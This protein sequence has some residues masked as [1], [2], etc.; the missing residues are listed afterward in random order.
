MTRKESRTNAFMLLFS[1]YAND[2]TIPEDTLELDDDGVIEVDDFCRRIIDNTRDNLTEIDSRI[3][4]HLQGWTIDRLP[5][6]S[7]AILRLSAAQLL[8][9][10]DIPVPVVISEAVELAKRFGSSNDYVFIN[11]ALSSFEKALA[12]GSG[13]SD[14]Q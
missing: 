4:S 8:Y 14:E 11:G 3:A 1:L 2:E 5:K 13:N 12:A 10:K 7:L 9:M 6:T